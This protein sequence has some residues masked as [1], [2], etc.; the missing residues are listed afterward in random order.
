MKHAVITPLLKKAG[1]NADNLASYRPMSQLS[2]VSKLLEKHVAIQVRHHME[3][4][5]LF[6]IFQSAYRSAH[7]CETA[8]V[9][10]HDDI[11]KA[12]DCGKH[13]I[14][15]L[16]DL[17]VDHDILF[18]KLHMVGVRGDTLS[19]VDSYL[20]ARTQVIRIGDATSQPIHLPCGV[21]QGSVLGTLLFN[22]YCHDL[23][24]VCICQTR[25]PL[26]YV[27]WRHLAVC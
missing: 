24:S 17:S 1:L 20:S 18:D 10:I 13:I 22:K 15:V 4:N 5:D 27:R 25:C 23:G 9:H 19:W 11:L 6:D 21:P 14:L 12:L 3:F 16:L 8:M 2:F 26:S 7:S